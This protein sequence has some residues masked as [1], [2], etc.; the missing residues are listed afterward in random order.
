MHGSKLSAAEALSLLDLAK[1]APREKLRTKYQ[2][3][4]GPSPD[5]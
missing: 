3:P 2:G 5:G 1:T 4:P